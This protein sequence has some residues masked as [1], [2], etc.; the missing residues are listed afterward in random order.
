MIHNNEVLGKTIDVISKFTDLYIDA[1]FY[2]V[3][4]VYGK[5]IIFFKYPNSVLNGCIFFLPL[6]NL[7]PCKIIIF[8]P[9]TCS[10]PN[11]NCI[12]APGVSSFF[13]EETLSQY[14]I[15]D[16]FVEYNAYPEGI[17]IDEYLYPVGEY[18]HVNQYGGEIYILP[19]VSLS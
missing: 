11:I 1:M 6:F 15:L 7:N 8:I 4:N 3:Q 5:I 9:L 18:C 17:N 13:P 14:G 10:K 16:F 19:A 2:I 12:Q